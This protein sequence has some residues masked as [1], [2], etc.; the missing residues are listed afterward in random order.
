[1]PAGPPRRRSASLPP[2]RRRLKLPVRAATISWPAVSWPALAARRV[3]PQPSPMSGPPLYG[4]CLPIHTERWEHGTFPADCL[5]P[6]RVMPT[7]RADYP[8]AP[9]QDGVAHPIAAP[10]YVFGRSGLAPPR[11]CDRPHDTTNRLLN[12]VL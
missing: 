10:D 8:P 5:V 3:C 2:P 6:C 4:S 1:M 11:Q 9:L 12:L 7:I